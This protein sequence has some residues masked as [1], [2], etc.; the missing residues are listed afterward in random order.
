M[1]RHG[2]RSV[3][4][5]A[6][7]LSVV[8]CMLKS[9][10]N[11]EGAE[12]S[13]FDQM[14]R[15]LRED[16]ARFFARF[17]R[18]FFGVGLLSHPVS[19]ALIDRARSQVVQDRMQDRMQD[20]PRARLERANGLASSGFRGDLEAFRVPTLI[21]HCTADRTVPIA[22]AGR[23][24]HAGIAQSNLLEHDGAPHGLFATEKHRLS[25]DL[26]SFIRR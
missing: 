11:P 2:S 24:A 16:R 21:V 20:S 26:I 23:A 6:L 5:A 4:K 15:G 13:A 17:F 12:Q 18:E 14:A 8:P 1:S 10:D 19:A 7:V 22:A 9:A 25:E 3:V